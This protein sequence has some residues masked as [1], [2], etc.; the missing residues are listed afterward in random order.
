MAGLM[1]VDSVLK[2]V[3]SIALTEANAEF[4]GIGA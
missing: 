4:M 1:R 3:Y 2:W